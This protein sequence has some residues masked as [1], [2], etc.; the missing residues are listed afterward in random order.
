MPDEKDEQYSNGKVVRSLLQIEEAIK[1][2]HRSDEVWNLYCVVAKR[3]TDTNLSERV[4]SYLA[5]QNNEVDWQRVLAITDS[6][7]PHQYLRARTIR[8]RINAAINVGDAQKLVQ[9]YIELLDAQSSLDPVAQVVR[10]MVVERRVLRSAASIDAAMFGEKPP[11]DSL[12]HSSS[13][14]LLRRLWKSRHMADGARFVPFDL[15][16]RALSP[17]QLMTICTDAVQGSDESDGD[18]FEGFYT[19]C[20]QQLL[21]VPTDAV[22]I[23]CVFD[24]LSKFDHVGFVIDQTTFEYVM[25]FCVRHKYYQ[26]AIDMYRAYQLHNELSLQSI[27]YG[28]RAHIGLGD[29]AG[30]RWLFEQIYAFGLEPDST[31]YYIIM[32]GFARIGRSDVVE[33][34]FQQFMQFRGT[35]TTQLF[36]ALISSRATVLDVPRAISWLHA[37][38]KAGLRRGTEHY[39]IMIRLFRK[40]KLDT[41]AIKYFTRM[42]RDGVVPDTYT[43]TEM[44]CVYKNLGDA[45]GAESFLALVDESGTPLNVYHFASLMAMYKELGMYKKVVDIALVQMKQRNLQPNIVV[46]NTLLHTYV[47]WG[48]WSRYHDLLR[49]IE[50]S[51]V[52][53]NDHTRSIILQARLHNAKIPRPAKLDS[54][55]DTLASVSSPQERSYIWGT[56]AMSRVFQGQSIRCVLRSFQHA[57]ENIN[58]PSHIAEAALL[59]EISR[60]GRVGVRRALKLIHRMNSN[61]IGIDFTQADG[62]RRLMSAKLFGAVIRG[63]TYQVRLGRRSGKPVVAD[64][65]KVFRLYRGQFRRRRA[66]KFD[67]GSMVNFMRAF[68]QRRRQRQVLQ[69]WRTIRSLVYYATRQVTE[70]G[71]RR[72]HIIPGREYA[73]VKPMLV[74]IRS[75]DA[76]RDGS[77]ELEKQWRISEMFGFLFDQHCFNERVQFLVRGGHWQAAMFAMER[78]C[79]L[80]EKGKFAR[81][82]S[83]T[84]IASSTL[85]T[86]W[87]MCQVVDRVNA[88]ADGVLSPSTQDTLRYH[89]LQQTSMS[90]YLQ[91]NRTEAEAAAR[92]AAWEQLPDPPVA[93][94]NQ[95]VSREK[96]PRYVEFERSRELFG[97]AQRGAALV[98]LGKG[99]RA[100]PAHVE[101][102]RAA[103]SRYI[104]FRLRQ[105]RLGRASRSAAP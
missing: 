3:L 93:A 59:Q 72:R 62:P 95:T 47:L 96:P 78:F 44:L 15:F 28:M 79:Q 9:F 17:Q 73:L 26:E 31:T 65:L 36:T 8:A 16:V 86:V 104:R 10:D 55:T 61:T 90:R 25:A 27:H 69:L 98:E 83:E 67:E 88:P 94:V 48:R 7:A 51:G 100:L 39:N 75:L 24:I 82:R 105:R 43:V 99:Y 102:R 30:L 23:A 42:I 54:L 29:L 49:Q 1:L 21:S 101:A 71:F 6:M 68:G 87:I 80:C 63:L 18:F 57:H 84:P 91:Q 22:T 85:R 41:L 81:S 46:Y 32:D 11:I 38:D 66:I 103:K 92:A 64:V 53:F 70:E 19:A 2:P 37:M 77:S 52:A 58:R 33:N 14:T 34:L 45:N 97:R 60:R 20:F 13:I 5:A 74:F 40:R 89:L 12:L 35:P 56:A 76:L 50:E 4:V